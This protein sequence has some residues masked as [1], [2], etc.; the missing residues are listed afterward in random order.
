MKGAKRDPSRVPVR[1]MRCSRLGNHG[2]KSGPLLNWVR[3]KC[4]ALT[5]GRL[6]LSAKSLHGAYHSRARAP[7]RAGLASPGHSIDAYLENI[8]LVDCLNIANAPGVFSISIDSIVI[9]L[10]LRRNALPLLCRRSAREHLHEP[11]LHQLGRLHL[12]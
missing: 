4:P 12:C 5:G 3:V 8:R 1:K 11:E 6:N 10:G 7:Y 9:A 2:T